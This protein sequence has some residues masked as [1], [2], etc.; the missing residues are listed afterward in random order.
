MD[1][2]TI[3][4]TFQ[5]S[6]TEE[7][8]FA[9]LISYIYENRMDQDLTVFTPANLA[10]L[11]TSKRQELDLEI[12]KVNTTRLKERLLMECPGLSAHS[13][14]RD[15]LIGFD[16]EIGLAMKKSRHNYDT[17]AYYI[18]MAATIVRKEVLRRQY[19]FD[20]TFSQN[21]QS[22]AIPASL[23]TLVNLIL[24]GPT[25]DQQSEE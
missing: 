6:I 5:E 2:D 23:Q 25:I 12:G 22:K 17:D 13:E 3:T 1:S 8:A 14:G 20:G 11:Y 9:E 21:C 15:V 4:K 16:R 10:K 24:K 7:M 19:H 18:F